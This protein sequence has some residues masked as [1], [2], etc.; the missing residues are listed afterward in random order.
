MIVYW[1]DILLAYAAY[2][3]ATLSP[4]PATL[5]IMS[6]A[7]HSGR[8]SALA[9]VAGV[10][11][12][13]MCWA[14]LAAVGLTGLMKSWGLAFMLVKV[15]GGMYLLWLAFCAARSALSGTQFVATGDGSVE[16]S[17]WHYFKRGLAIHATNPKAALAWIAIVS[18][19]LNQQATLINT[20]ILLGGC[21][22]LGILTFGSYAMLFSTQFMVAV[23]RRCQ[24]TIEVLMAAL[25][26]VAGVKLLTTRLSDSH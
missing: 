13:S 7:M 22:L 15:I 21:A 6:V 12:I 16:D 14:I 11:I 17:A 5:A 10:L 3:I 8:R 20:A 26:G 19:G 23:Y 2:F 1:Q 25:F 9:M 18:I 24:R 4:G